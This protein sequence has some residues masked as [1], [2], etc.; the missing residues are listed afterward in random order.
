[1]P[2]TITDAVRELLR[3]VD[4]LSRTYGKRKFT[5]DGRLVGAIGEV[6]AEEAYDL[7]LFGGTTKHYDGTC[8]D[9]RLVQIKATMKNSLTFPADHT[10]MLYLGLLIHNDGSLA[11]IFNGPGVIAREAV[12]DRSVPKTNLHSITL[13]SLKRLQRRVL[14]GET[15]PR[16]A[17]K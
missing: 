11:E 4:E 1:M 14:P 2:I 8:S 10:P 13:S 16:R 7:T 3:I 5:L 9:G 6:L 12:Q 17:G 15:I